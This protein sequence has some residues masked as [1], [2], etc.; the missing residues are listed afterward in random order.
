[1]KLSFFAS[2]LDRSSMDQSTTEDSWGSTVASCLMAMVLKAVQAIMNDETP[3]H[4]PSHPNL[5]SLGA[6]TLM[7][8]GTHEP[9]SRR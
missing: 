7:F 2:W 5:F 3:P 8:I 6:M 1:M 4:S 9:K